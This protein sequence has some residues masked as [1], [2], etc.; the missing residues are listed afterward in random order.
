[1][2]TDELFFKINLKERIYLEYAVQSSLERVQRPHTEKIIILQ[3]AGVKTETDNPQQT[4][5]HTHIYTAHRKALVRNILTKCVKNVLKVLSTNY[6][7]M[8]QP[9]YISRMKV[10]FI[11]LSISHILLVSTEEIKY[12]LLL[13]CPTGSQIIRSSKEAPCH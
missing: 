10:F 13:I 6:R 4:H 8:Q 9:D 7:E 3:S 1:M 12:H 11:N 2:M 5:T